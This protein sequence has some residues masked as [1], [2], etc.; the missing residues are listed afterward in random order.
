MKARLTL[1]ALFLTSPIWFIPCGAYWAI[2]GETTLF[3]YT[4][5]ITNKII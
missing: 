4:A 2:S 1:I 3:G 5:H